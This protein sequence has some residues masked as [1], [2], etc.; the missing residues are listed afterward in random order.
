[1]M[2]Y[3]V[4]ICLVC[5]AYMRV[6]YMIVLEIRGTRKDNGCSES[7][8]EDVRFQVLIFLLEGAVSDAYPALCMGPN[9]SILVLDLGNWL[10]E[11]APVVSSSFREL[12]S[13]REYV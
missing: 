9:C 12:R 7:M 1:M 11:Y 8:P 6:T 5:G 13:S 10:L 2:V 3:G 4:N